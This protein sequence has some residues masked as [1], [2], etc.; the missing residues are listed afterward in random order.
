M[1]SPFLS[2]QPIWKKE[3]TQIFLKCDIIQNYL[4]WLLRYFDT[5]RITGKPP[6]PDPIPCIPGAP[7]PQNAYTSPSWRPGHLPVCTC[8]CSRVSALDWNTHNAHPSCNSIPQGSWHIQ[9]HRIISSQ[10]YRDDRFQSE[11]ARLVNTRDNQ[12][13]R[14]KYKDINNRNQHYLASSEPSSTTIA[15]PG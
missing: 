8:V 7:G 9:G 2:L 14:D 11:T 13:A 1:L 6:N 10:A 3:K 15:S 4:S 12:M 5:S